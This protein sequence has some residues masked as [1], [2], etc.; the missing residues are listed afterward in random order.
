MI[1]VLFINPGSH[2][3]IYQDLAKEYSAIEP[4]TWSL[5]LAQSVRSIGFKPA[6]LDLAAERLSAEEVINRIKSIETRL[7]CFVV[8]GQNPNS[9]T[10]NMQ[11]ALEVSKALKG[12]RIKTPI[13]FVGSH[14][15]ALPLEVLNTEESIDLVFCNEG[16][17]ALRNILKLE[18]LGI[19]ISP[20][21][22]ADP[23]SKTN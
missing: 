17:Y 10:V 13:A 8:Y 4:P 20:P 22:P 15:S 23:A 18:S 5:L 7:I 12:E 16:V 9:G 14:V 11:G 21:F 6:I 19:N 1:D 2:N 3:N